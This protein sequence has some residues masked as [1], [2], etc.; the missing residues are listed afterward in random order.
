M[1][2]VGM[3]NKLELDDGILFTT[4]TERLPLKS[5]ITGRKIHTECDSIIFSLMFWSNNNRKDKLKP[6]I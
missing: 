2:F 4:Y 1:N 5:V 6:T 3:A